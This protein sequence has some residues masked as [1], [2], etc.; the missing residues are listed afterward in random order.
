MELICQLAVLWHDQG[1]ELRQ[2][3]AEMKW[4]AAMPGMAQTLPE[5]SRAL[6][7]PCRKKMNDDPLGCCALYRDGDLIGPVS[8]SQLLRR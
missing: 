7:T 3:R 5:K 4:R 1:I 8:L 2:I 6:H